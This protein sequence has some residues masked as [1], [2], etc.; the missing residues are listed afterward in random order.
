MWIRRFIK[1]LGDEDP[2]LPLAQGDGDPGDAKTTRE[3]YPQLNSVQ[4][5]EAIFRMM[6]K[7][8]TLRMQVLKLANAVET[9]QKLILTITKDSK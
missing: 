8:D 6:H 9:M 3:P 1:P 4:Q 7:M 5:D 2:N